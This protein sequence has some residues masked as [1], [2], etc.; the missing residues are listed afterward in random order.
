MIEKKPFVSYKD[1]SEREL[2]TRRT[3]TVSINKKEELWL[4]EGRQMLN[5]DSESRTLKEL[6]KI[7]LNV[8]HCTFG[9]EMITYLTR[10]NR[11]RY[12]DGVAIKR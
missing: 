10:E 4:K 12:N 6:A 8:L 2:D 9:A 3:F 5:V 7:G 11:K 1:E